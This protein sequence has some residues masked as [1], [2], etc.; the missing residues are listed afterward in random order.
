MY[1]FALS[2]TCVRPRFRTNI[3]CFSEV[4][5]PG[6]RGLLHSHWVCAAS[7]SLL[8]TPARPAD[9]RSR[10]QATASG[11]CPLHTTRW[12][13]ETCAQSSNSLLVHRRPAPH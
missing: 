13:L 12:H 6:A 3:T 7:W 4:A 2:P 10:F 5:R 8:G 9:K 1:L 11:P